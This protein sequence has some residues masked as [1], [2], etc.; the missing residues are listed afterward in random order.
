MFV[1]TTVPITLQSFVFEQHEFRC[2]EMDKIL[3]EINRNKYILPLS[4]FK[5][6]IFCVSSYLSVFRGMMGGTIRSFRG[7]HLQASTMV[8]YWEGIVGMCCK[9]QSVARNGSAYLLL[10]TTPVLKWRKF[11]KMTNSIAS[12]SS[13]SSSSSACGRCWWDCDMPPDPCVERGGGAGG[14]R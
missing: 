2:D 6:F 3:Y 5:Q 7:K 14:V 1:W 12:S 10:H 8:W 4:Y 13:S 9:N 11:Y